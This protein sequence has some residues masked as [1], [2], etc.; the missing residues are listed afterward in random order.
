MYVVHTSNKKMKTVKRSFAV[1]R[2]ARNFVSKIDG[3]VYCAV[4]SGNAVALKD[5]YENY[6]VK[7]RNYVV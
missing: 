2:V 4:L 1:R 5:F 6:K 3:I 7:S